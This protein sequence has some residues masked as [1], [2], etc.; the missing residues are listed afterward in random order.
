MDETVNFE[1]YM[2]RQSLKEKDTHKQVA[3]YRKD[4]R[5]GSVLDDIEP[6]MEGQVK[7]EILL[8]AVQKL[9]CDV[10]KFRECLTQKNDP[11]LE[12]TKQEHAK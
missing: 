6:D 9:E 11:F 4:I 5:E 7:I 8:N 10:L 3:K 2:Y 1:L 12:E